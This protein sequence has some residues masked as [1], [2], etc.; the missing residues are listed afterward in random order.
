MTS[1]FD[2]VHYGLNLWAI[3]PIIVGACLVLLAILIVARESHFFPSHVLAILL[4]T[5]S[6]WLFT[7][8]GIFSAIDEDT[9]Y[10]WSKLQNVAVAFIPS[11]LFLFSLAIVQRAR[12]FR[13]L[14]IV[15][16]VTSCF[17]A[18]IAFFTRDFVA[19]TYQY[20]WGYYARY[21]R[22]GY[23]FLPFFFIFF[24]AGLSLLWGEY[25]RA[26]IP[27]SKARL[28]NLLIAFGIAQFGAID[29]LPAL[30]IGVYPVGYLPA[31]VFFLMVTWIVWHARLAK[32]LPVLTTRQITSAIKDVLIVLDAEGAIRIVNHAACLFFQRPQKELVGMPIWNLD[33]IFMSQKKFSDLIQDLNP[34]NYTVTLFRQNAIERLLSISV[35]PILD[36]AHER[37]GLICIGR[38]ITEERKTEQSLEQRNISML[39]LNFITGAT[40]KA[41]D[42]KEVIEFILEAVCQHTG[43]VIG[44]AY[45]VRGN[46]SQL[47]STRIWHLKDSV[48]YQRFKDFSEKEVLENNALAT[49]IVASRQALWVPDLRNEKRFV[50]RSLAAELGLRGGFFLPILVADE[51]VCIV[52]FFSEKWGDPDPLFQEI[53]SYIGAQIGRVFERRRAEE[54][55]VSIE[56]RFQT[57]LD[58][59]PA[60]VYLKDKEGRYLFVNRYFESLSLRHRRDVIGKTDYDIFPHDLAESYRHHDQMALESGKPMEFEETTR[61][62]E[63]FRTYIS[64]KFPLFDVVGSMYGVGGVSTDIT[65]RK[66]I[67]ESLR[68]NEERFRSVAE[69]ANDAIVLANAV[70]NIIFWN[71]TAERMFGYSASEV[72]G[73]P[74]TILMPER[75]RDGHRKGLERLRNTGESRLIGRRIELVGLNKTGAEFPIE[76]SLSSWKTSDT[77]FYSGIIQDISVRKQAEDIIRQSQSELERRVEERTLELEQINR[78]L[79]TEVE[80]RRSVED[81]LKKTASDL[82]RSNQELEQ[83]AYV[84]SHDLQE[85]LRMVAAYT[86]LL[87]ERYTEK[88]DE[89]GREFL[90]FAAEG[91][92]RAQ[93]LIDGLLQ[94]SRVERRGQNFTGISSQSVLDQ[95]IQ[96]LKILIEES[97]TR[98]EAGPLPQV[99]GDE[100]QLVQ[101]FQNLISNAIKFR[102][103]Q[104]APLLQIKVEKSGDQWLFSVRDNGIGFDPKYADR[105]FLIFQRLHTRREYPGTGIGLAIVQRIILRH[106]GKIWA[107]S[108]LGKGSTFFFTLPQAS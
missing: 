39:L 1:I 16:L 92:V 23:A 46:S 33:N 63:G 105:I 49:A 107:Q 97:G 76:L 26:V 34:G 100:I 85:P 68:E 37:I 64:I 86:Q 67:E 45:W 43:W 71:R 31:F 17:F 6:G 73:K 13:T 21:G 32:I 3:P 19:G 103:K 40:Q 70:G 69:S 84:A 74:L 90:G 27:Q 101:V 62:M 42:I 81:N 8:A 93:Q 52:E 53:M 91:A 11:L 44:H 83:F 79:Q 94:Y 80:A 102:K 20:S 59:A 24:V 9:A 61:Q 7:Y 55:L 75:F 78:H 108:E 54:K 22:L 66:R 58:N 98:I 88:I 72:A 18:G 12:E 99:T 25:R 5:G 29:Y 96:N 35:S 30:G 57:I 14:V 60:V 28:R 50:R 87:A 95:A 36:T 51:V 106:G 89:A 48:R 104:E 15:A 41:Q 2:A 38:D 10:L 77:V 56:E 65:E 4:L 82:A 47:V